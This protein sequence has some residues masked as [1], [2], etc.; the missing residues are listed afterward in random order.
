MVT[1]TCHPANSCAGGY[2]NCLDVKITNACNDNCAWSTTKRGSMFR[3]MRCGAQ[4][5]FFIRLVYLS[6]S[7]QI[8]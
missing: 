7:T 6:E 5:R 1:K 4:Y 8:W 2:G 3:S